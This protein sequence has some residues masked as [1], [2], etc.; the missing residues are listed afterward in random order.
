MDPVV[1]CLCC[2]RGRHKC[3]ER[4]VK[5]FID[6]D[7]KGKHILLIY[8][9]STI[10]QRLDEIDLP[11]NKQI[12]LINN[13]KDLKTNQPY[14]STGAIF[15][16]ACTFIPNEVEIV[17]ITDDDDIYLSDHITEGSKGIIRAIE[18]GKSVYKPYYSYYKSSDDTVLA[19][20][21]LEP[22]T[23]L[24][25]SYLLEKGFKLTAVDYHDGWLQ[26][27]KDDGDLFIDPNGKPTFIYDWSGE[28]KVHKI[29]G[30]MNN[31]NNFKN[32]ILHSLD[33]GD[34]I[35]TPMSDSEVKKYYH[36]KDRQK[37]FG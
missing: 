28:F 17:A 32:H 1:L 13:S 22:S 3:L 4:L 35:I 19:H 30:D 8:N 18:V 2:T 5:N 11:E 12:I 7:Y 9:N 10:E 34:K 24:L 25:K 23:F 37:S 6:Q 26:P 29:S 14:T 27:A 31:P 16:D 36:E 33:E 21:N 20:N 15:R